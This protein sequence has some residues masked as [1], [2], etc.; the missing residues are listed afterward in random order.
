MGGDFSDYYRKIANDPWFFISEVVFTKNQVSEGDAIQRFPY[1]REYL[2]LYVRMWQKNKL[3]AVPKSRRMTLSWTNVALYL[4]AAMFKADQ[5]F[6]F[7]SKKEDDAAELVRRAEFIFDRIPEDKIPRELLPNKKTYAKPPALIFPSIGSKIQGFPMGADQLRQFTF[8]GILGDECAFWDEAENF[9]SAAYP[10]IEGGG[11][12]SLI[13][14]RA[15]G[16]FQRLVYDQ[17]DSQNTIDESVTPPKLYPFSDDSVII[18]KNPKN[19]FTV[20]DIHYTADKNKKAPEFK[21][22]IKSGMPIKKFMVEYERFWDAFSGKPVYEDYSKSRHESR[23]PIEPHLG[24]PLLLGWDFGLTPACVVAQLREGVLF[25]IREY[26]AEHSG[27][28]K[29]CPRVMGDLSVRYP[30]WRDPRMDFRHYVDPAGLAESQTDQRTC[31]GVMSECGLKNIFP[32]II[33]FEGRR[34]AVED[35][36]ILHTKEGPG[37]QLYEPDCPQLS[38]GFVGGYCYPEKYD[39]IEPGKPRPLKNAFSHP[40]DA[41][42]YLAGG[43]SS[44]KNSKRHAQIPVPEYSFA[45]G[46]KAEPSQN[47][48]QIS[49][50]DLGGISGGR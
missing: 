44:L 42:Q 29:F 46:S 47:E 41:L 16:F 27:I 1:E 26:V 13:S 24:L 3:I 40:H 34:K 23:E 50:S 12:M 8:S 11:R 7:V 14:S 2:R 48:Y 37:L 4:H 31:A 36:L 45:R 22:A 6:A 38:K 15:P 19:R 10:T 43:A 39:Q 20:I 5:D 9:Y 25:I 28:Q 18:W 49:K 33:D 17:L 21:S 35:F 32:G 30:G